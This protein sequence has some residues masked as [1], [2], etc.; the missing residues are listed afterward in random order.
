MEAIYFG[1]PILG[2]PLFADQPKS[3]IIAEKEGYGRI[4]RYNNLTTSNILWSVREL[5]KNNR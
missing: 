5:I 2:I 3:L 4:L 1:V